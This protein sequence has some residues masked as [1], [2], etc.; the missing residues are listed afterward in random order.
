MMYE[1]VLS[2]EAER[3]FAAA[4]VAL[5]RKLAR[6][7]ARLEADPRSG[8]NVKKQSGPLAGL[9]RYRVGDMRVVYAIDDARRIVSVLTIAHRRNVYD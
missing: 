2:R 6:C 9:F 7:F 8:N 3:V 5:G 4:D 1:V